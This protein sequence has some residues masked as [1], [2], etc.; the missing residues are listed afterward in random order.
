[1]STTVYNTIMEVLLGAALLALLGSIGC[2]VGAVV[3]WRTPF[4]R[5]RCLW[6]AGLFAGT[7]AAIAAQQAVLWWGFL[8][9]FGRA[10]RQ[11]HDQA[12]AEAS[13][14]RLGELAPG[15][16]IRADDGSTVDS[17]KLRGKVVVLNFFATWCG[18]CLE[19][20]P[21][22]Q[23]LW[24]EFGRRDDF[25]MLV[26]GREETAEK[27]AEFKARKGFT[28]PMAADPERSV[29]DRYATQLIPRTYVLSRDGKIL[30]QTV[31]FHPDEID[32]MKKLVARELN[33]R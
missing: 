6:S 32:A 26:V 24:E 30:F 10:L 33:S 12:I 4:R 21:H 7:V 2:L 22:V 1:M 18:P 16:S 13:L 29:Y 25:A 27:V 3:G 23:Q 19:E 8:P 9:T 17:A 11:G 20:L 28:F 14:T 31:G 5:R 15:F